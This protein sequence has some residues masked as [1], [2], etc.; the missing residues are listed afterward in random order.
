[1]KGGWLVSFLI[2]IILAGLLLAVRF[3]PLGKVGR[4]YWEGSIGLWCVNE[5]CFSKNEEKWRVKVGDKGYLV[6]KDKIAPV[7]ATLATVKLEQVASNNENKFGDLG[8]GNPDKVVIKML[9]KDL[10]IG[11]I[12]ERYDGTYVRA[13]GDK[14]V[15]KIAGVID[16]RSITNLDFWRK[17]KVTNISRYQV[18]KITV[19]V[20]DKN[21]ELKHNQ[22]KW[23]NEEVVSKLTFLDGA[24][25]EGMKPDWKEAVHYLVEM[26]EGQHELWLIRVE[27]DKMVRY[28]ASDNREDV[29]E[30]SKVDFEKLTRWKL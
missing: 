21:R 3:W 11:N 22:E 4:N 16:R 13:D 28:L 20:G 24:Y 8:I 25:I 12:S 23:E 10:E 15:Y 17:N 7:V 27:E 19:Y 5:L 30:I 29:Y 6:D 9:G 2:V 26:E 18:R 14:V 1:M